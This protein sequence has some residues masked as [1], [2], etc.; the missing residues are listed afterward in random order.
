MSF[1][2]YDIVYQEDQVGNFN[3][4]IKIL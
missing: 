1:S 3:F 4:L 2:I